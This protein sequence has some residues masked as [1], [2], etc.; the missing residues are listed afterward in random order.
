MGYRP[1]PP[2]LDSEAFPAHVKRMFPAV[3]G[4]CC[5]KFSG[6][7]RTRLAL[8]RLFG[9]TV[10]AALRALKAMPLL[11]HNMIIRAIFWRKEPQYG[12][13]SQFPRRFYGVLFHELSENLCKV[14]KF[15]K[16]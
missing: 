7:V 13:K 12:S 1:S 11:S 3:A 16:A 9:T 15:Y 2:G 8:H 5:V 10:T 14:N 4:Y 6:A